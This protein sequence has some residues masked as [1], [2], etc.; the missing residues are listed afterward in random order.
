M[1]SQIY[2]A[3]L[4]DVFFIKKIVLLFINYFELKIKLSFAFTIDHW[5]R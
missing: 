2:A 3:R 4:F 5:R 1:N